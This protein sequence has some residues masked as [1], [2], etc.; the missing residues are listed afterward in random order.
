MQYLY[1]VQA[2]NEKLSEKLVITTLPVYS[3]DKNDVG[4]LVDDPV[5]RLGEAFQL[6]RKAKLS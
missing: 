3:D 1:N 5:N 6:L 4:R 2:F